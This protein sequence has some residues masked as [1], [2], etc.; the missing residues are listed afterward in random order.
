MGHPAL[1]GVGGGRDPALRRGGLLA[2]LLPAA[3]QAGPAALR[4][5][6]RLAALVH[7]DRLQRLLR[8]LRALAVR[9]AARGRRD[10][11]RQAAVD[12]L[13][14]RPPA[15]HGP[16]PRQGRGRGQPEVHGDQDPRAR[17]VPRRAAAARGQAGLLPRGHAAPR[18]H[19]RPD[20]RVDPARG[21]LR[22]LRRGRRRRLRVRTA[23]RAQHGLSGPAPA[24]G[25]AH[26]AAQLQGQG[27]HRR[28]AARAEHVVRQDLHAAAH[29]HLDDQG[30]GHRHLGALRLARRLR[31]VHGPQEPQEARVLRRGRRVGRALRAAAHHRDA[32]PRQGE[33]RVRLPEAQGA[34][35]E[36]RGE[37]QG[38]ARRLLQLG[39]LQG[40]HDRGPLRGQERAGGQAALR[41]E[42]R[43]RRRGLLL[44]RARG[45]RH[46]ALLARRRVRRR[47]RRPV[48]PQVRR[49][50]VEGQGGRPAHAARVLQPRGDQGLPGRPRLAG[51]LGVLALLRAGHAH[52]VGRAVPHRVALRLDHLHGLLHGG[53]PAPGRRPLRQG[54]RR[55][56]GGRRH[57][58][59]VHRGLLGLRLPRRQVRRRA[60]RARGR[61]EEAAPRVP[62]LVPRRHARLGQGPHPQPPDHVALQPHRRV[63]QAAR[64]VAE[65]HLL[66]RLRAGGRGEDVQVQGQLRHDEGRHRAVGRGR[67]A[68]HVRRRGRRRR[69]RQLRPRHLGPHHPQ[70][71]DRARVDRDDAQGHVQAGGRHQPEPQP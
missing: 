66:Q 27:A 40:R 29:D 5:R 33:R 68:L 3:G 54:A 28:G 67:D 44:L 16:R 2:A 53:A 35:P 70:P 10:R 62:V 1:D 49:G 34:E 12:L 55:Q 64:D 51:Q 32:R 11:L 56:H 41:A 14:G 38:G 37:A 31:G 48:V 42:A 6:H 46:A 45:A 23:R 59:A 69:Q 50:G 15:V 24:V 8:L 63:A 47:A 52:A 20:Q 17:A 13:R 71:H 58:R 18:D 60:R 21:R 36:G 26:A 43:R 30:H 57:A 65:E 7:H 19:V 25:H 4:L 9:Q 61:H 39:L 22:R